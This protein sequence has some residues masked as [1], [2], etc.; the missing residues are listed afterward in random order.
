MISQVSLYQQEKL[1]TATKEP[2]YIDTVT[3][4]LCIKYTI[5][6][7]RSVGEEKTSYHGHEPNKRPLHLQGSLSN[8]QLGEISCLSL[9]IVVAPKQRLHI[10]S[11]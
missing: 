11:S 1:K 7:K 8:E 4:L 5:L 3:Q 2:R 6:T 10:E 9:H